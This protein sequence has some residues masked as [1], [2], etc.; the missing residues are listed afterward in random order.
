MFQFKAKGLANTENAV[1]N[2]RNNN[3]PIPKYTTSK[4]ISSVGLS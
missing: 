4:A 1:I 2:S 3:A